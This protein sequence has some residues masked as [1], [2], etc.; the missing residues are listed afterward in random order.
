MQFPETKT[1]GSLFYD[2][3]NSLLISLSPYDGISFLAGVG[4]TKMPLVNLHP[5]SVFPNLKSGFS[6]KYK[7]NINQTKEKIKKY[8]PLTLNQ[9]VKDM[10]NIGRRLDFPFLEEEKTSLKHTKQLIDEIE[11]PHVFNDILGRF[12]QQTDFK[13]LAGDVSKQYCFA[14]SYQ[15]KSLEQMLKRNY[16][17]RY[18]KFILEYLSNVEYKEIFSG[19]EPLLILPPEYNPPVY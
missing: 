12:N 13:A 6:L 11:K 17:L 19:I 15:K 9:L 8:A 18:M 5:M 3:M 7:P 2:W 14:G 1:R 10:I 4:K 16:G